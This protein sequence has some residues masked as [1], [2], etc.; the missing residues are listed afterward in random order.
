MLIDFWKKKNTRHVN[1]QYMKHQK[2]HYLLYMTHINIISFIV[3]W[4]NFRHTR[5]S[6]NFRVQICLTSRTSDGLGQIFFFLKLALLVRTDVI[7]LSSQFQRVQFRGLFLMT[8]VC[9]QVLK[10]IWVRG[11][12]GKLVRG[13]THPI[14]LPWR[15]NSSQGSV[16]EDCR[17]KRQSGLMVI[18]PFI[19]RR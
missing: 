5:S 19:P 14:R 7:Y 16:E 3:V 1:T 4:T 15:S 9:F 6:D 2:T 17:E 18:V 11:C 10:V 8:K 13:L 12:W